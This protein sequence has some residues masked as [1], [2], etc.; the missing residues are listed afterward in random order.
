MFGDEEAVK[1]LALLLIYNIGIEETIKLAPKEL[2]ERA[3]NTPAAH[4]NN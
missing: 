1:K 4:D 3:L 2:W